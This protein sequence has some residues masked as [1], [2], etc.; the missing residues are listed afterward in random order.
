M[1]LSFTQRPHKKWKSI[2]LSEERFYYTKHLKFNAFTLLLRCL[3]NLFTTVSGGVQKYSSL[4]VFI[5]EVLLTIQKHSELSTFTPILWWLSK[6]LYLPLFYR[7][8]FRTFSYNHQAPSKF[9]MFYRKIIET[10][11]FIGRSLVKELVWK[12]SKLAI[13]TE[14]ELSQGWFSRDSQKC[15]KQLFQRTYL[16]R[17]LCWR[18]L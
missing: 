4:C 1:P 13:Y 18:V 17:Y 8:T 5:L 10:K 15:S 12:F 9:S 2:I 3:S 6:G 7:Q 14:S 11:A 16:T